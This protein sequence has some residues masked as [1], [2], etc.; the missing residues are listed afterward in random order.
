MGWGG[1]ELS[2]QGG[3]A[4]MNGTDAR[5]EQQPQQQQ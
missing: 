1:A 4:Y 5:Q 2:R 3:V